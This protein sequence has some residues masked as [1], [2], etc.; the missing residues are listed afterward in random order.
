M[1][2]SVHLQLFPNV[3]QISSNE[4]LL[5]KM[6]TIRAI[7]NVALSIRKENNIR[8]RLP[9]SS[10]TIYSKVSVDL[11][12]LTDIIQDELNVKTIVFSSDFH[13]VA[14]EF[15]TVNM[16]L[17]G[18]KY[19]KDLK[20]IVTAVNQG[21]YTINETK[22][23]LKIGEITLTAEE[24]TTGL[25]LKTTSANTRIVNNNLV[26]ELNTTLTEELQQ[27]GIVRDIIRSVQEIRKE[28]NLNL[29]D[30]IYLQIQSESEYITTIISQSHFLDEINSQTLAKSL[31]PSSAAQV[32]QQTINDHPV[33][34][35]IAKA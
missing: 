21:N 16:K 31:K 23:E 5:N 30:E 14:E 34:I 20:N 8:V 33:T 3:L 2:K 25:R 22:T 6:D 26:I 15:T 12:D 35:A 1:T 29:S 13:N 24:F 4:L 9:L 27:E 7:C 17:C 32:F 19:G 11:T 28:L 18:A 10:L